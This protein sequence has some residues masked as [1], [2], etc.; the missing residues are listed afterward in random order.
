MATISRSGSSKSVITPHALNSTSSNAVG[1]EQ[2]LYLWVLNPNVRYSSSRVRGSKTSIKI[3]YK[4]ITAEEGLGL[5]ESM[6][7][8]VQEITLPV[9]AI[10]ATETELKSSTL[11]LPARE[12]KFKEWD[13]GLLGRWESG[14]KEL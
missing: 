2:N 8:D 14:Q 10:S 13:V 11:L 1:P 9:D 4:S 3:L 12:R 7:S 6:T 5:I